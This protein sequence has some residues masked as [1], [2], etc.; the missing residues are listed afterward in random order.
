MTQED[1]VVSFEACNRNPV[2][3]VFAV[4]LV[5]KGLVQFDLEYVV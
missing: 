4:G 2:R 3:L 1:L 5:S